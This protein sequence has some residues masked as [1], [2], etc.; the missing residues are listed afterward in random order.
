MPTVV[1][2]PWMKFDDVPSKVTVRGESRLAITLAS[3]WL[4]KIR[5]P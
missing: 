4:L 3:K 5:L 2:D 1:F